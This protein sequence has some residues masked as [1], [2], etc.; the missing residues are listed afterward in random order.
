MKLTPAAATSTWTSPSVGSGISWSRTCRTLRSPGSETKTL[1]ARFMLATLRLRPPPPRA[2]G[3]RGPG[4]AD[5]HE[6]GQ[7]VLECREER[8]GVGDDGLVGHDPDADGVGIRDD[9]EAERVPPRPGHPAEH[10]RHGD[11]AEVADLPRA[12]DVR[13]HA[14]RLVRE[15]VDDPALQLCGDAADDGDERE[16]ERCLGR[17]LEPVHPRLR[18]GEAPEGRRVATREAQE[19]EREAVAELA[20]ERLVERSDVD[21][22]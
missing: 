15:E 4:L 1:V 7:L 18:Q 22:H 14:D 13:R 16:G 10:A 6:Q 2:G 12:G 20:R 19:D 5:A 11:A 3:P 9:A 17:R 21:R 8:L